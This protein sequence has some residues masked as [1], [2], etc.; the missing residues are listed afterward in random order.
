MMKEDK[1]KGNVCMDK[2]YTNNVKQ[3]LANA[4]ELATKNKQIQVDIP[5]LWSDFMTPNEFV[6]E[7]YESLDI[8]INEMIQIINKE[9]DKIPVTHGSN[10]AYA[11]QRTA[12]YERLI[13]QA[14]DEADLLRDEI[15]S[16]EHFILA[17]MNQTYNPI[18]SF[19][20][21]HHIDREVILEK[22]KRVRKGKRAVSESQETIYQA[23]DQY[24]ENLNQKYRLGKVGKIIGREREIDEIIR[25]LTRKTKNNAIL[26]GLPGVGKTAIVEGLVQRIEQGIVPESLRDKEVY[27]LDMSSLVAGA[28]YRGEF[29]ER[30]KAV[31]NDVRDSQG[32]I[33]LFIDEI[34]TIVGAGKTEGSMDA[35]NILKPM[36]ARGELRCIG[37]TTQ[38]EYREN[39]EKDKALERRFQRIHISEPTIEEAIEILS[40]IKEG[41]EL[42]HGVEIS[43]AAVKAAVTLANRYM[44]DRFLPDKA[45]DLMDEASAVRHIQMKSLPK[46]IQALKDQIVQ[47]TIEKIKG[48]YGYTKVKRES[49]VAGQ[50]LAHLMSRLEDK[51]QE[52]QFEQAI[53]QEIQDLNIAKKRH[54]NLAKEALSNSALEEFVHITEGILPE[55]EANIERL[56]SQRQ[57]NVDKEL[58]YI[59]HVVEESDIAEVVERQTGIKVQGVMENERQSLL[60]LSDIIK[61]RVVGQDEAVEKVT[62]AIIRSRAGVQNPNHP[63]GSFLFLGPTGVGKTQLAKTLADV[64]FGSELEMVRLDMSEFMEKH[65]VAKLVGPPPGYVGYEEGGQLTEAVRHR[66]YSVVL[67]DEIEKAHPDVF[68]ILLQVLDEGRLT[69][70]Q[71]RTID[72]K[73]TILIMTSNIGSLKILEGLQQAGRISEELTKAVN[74]DLKHHFRPEFLNRIDNILL[75]NPLT[76]DNMHDIVKLMAEELAERLARHRIELILSEEAKRWI[77]ENGYDPTLG[78]RPL[79]RF[80]MDQ[81]ETPLAM[82]LIKQDIVSDSL[83]LVKVEKNRLTFD[84]TKK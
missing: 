26:M 9:V 62:Q 46:E 5:H 43:E 39:I 70:S 28:K 17:L 64:L 58:V 25:V 71:G 59:R 20:L 56:E 40:G 49:E 65:A 22:L 54:Q 52:W 72:F 30:L 29:E 38:D 32:R 76:L 50:Q 15:C 78:A 63:I 14:A 36:L 34:H 66:L 12:R 47:L 45:I 73:N 19:L 24:S 16:S 75:F 42:Y 61:E 37:A 68:N 44:T 11:Q 81:L 41:Y 57:E 10:I 21:K 80:I 8:D 48:D 60:N 74:D 83:A 6:F 23:L 69:D 3:A 31:L 7:F 51:L 2:K 67:L 27:N 55:I 79:Q 53:I 33:V 4:Q 35:G 84:Y 13:Q 77:V 1:W 18:T 82:E